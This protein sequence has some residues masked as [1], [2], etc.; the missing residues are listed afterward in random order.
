MGYNVTKS[1]VKNLWKKDETQRK[2]EK[3]FNK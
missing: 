1:R 3:V 2:N